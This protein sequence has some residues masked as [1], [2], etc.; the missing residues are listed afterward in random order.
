MEDL[1]ASLANCTRKKAKMT[2]LKDNFNIWEQ[3]AGWNHLF[4]P[5]SEE[6]SNGGTIQGLD[7]Q[8]KIVTPNL[9]KTEKISKAKSRQKV[10]KTWWPSIHQPLLSK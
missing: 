2:I 10:D 8:G 9:T 1:E 6:Y 7:S 3:G 5:L 4:A